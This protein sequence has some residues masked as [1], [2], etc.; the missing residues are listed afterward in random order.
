MAF[1]AGV[2]AFNTDALG[3]GWGGHWAE[4]SA[5]GLFTPNEAACSS[6]F[7][8]VLAVKLFFLQMK[9]KMRQ[10]LYAPF[11]GNVTPLGILQ[12]VVDNM[13]VRDI[14]S[15]GSRVDALNQIVKE[16]WDVAWDRG[17]VWKAF[18]VPR[19]HNVRADMLSKAQTFSIVLNPESFKL[20]YFC[21]RVRP[22]CQVFT[23]REGV[24]PMVNGKY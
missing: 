10:R 7:R 1:K 16:L 18:W 24:L 13:A 2:I 23:G 21:K 22:T 5:S 15:W 17:F 4:F 6:T 3:V 12:P 20:F 11:S 8:E 9:E 14:M 19:E